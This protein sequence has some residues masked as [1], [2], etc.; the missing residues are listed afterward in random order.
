MQEECKPKRKPQKKKKSKN[1]NDYKT[2]RYWRRLMQVNDW[3]VSV[4]QNLT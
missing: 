1:G 3:M 2:K 4:P